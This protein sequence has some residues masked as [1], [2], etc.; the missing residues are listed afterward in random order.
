MT[1]PRRSGRVSSTTSRAR[2]AARGVGRPRPSEAP[3]RRAHPRLAAQVG[4]AIGLALDPAK[5]VALKAAREPNAV[6]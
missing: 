6:A 1:C 4:T 2:P 3:V 5:C